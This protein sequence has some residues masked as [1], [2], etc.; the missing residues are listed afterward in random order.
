MI[1]DEEISRIKVSMARR[2]GVI[3][4]TGG[5]PFEVAVAQGQLNQYLDLC[6]DMGFLRIECG[7]GF[8]DIDLEPSAVV[9]MAHDRGLEVQF[10]LGEKHAGSFEANTVE[11]LIEQGKRWLDAGAVH[12]IVEGRE[13]AAEVGIFSTDG[14]L[15]TGFA[16]RFADAFGLETVIFEA[17]TKPSQ[18]ALLDHF[19][20]HVRLSNV[21]LEE[22]LR[23][24]IY[25]RGLH[26]DAFSN[27]RLRPHLSLAPAEPPGRPE[28]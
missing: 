16:E 7:E 13:N 27:P 9:E 28:L 8:T 12:L 11:A 23:V 24:E 15:H 20:P 21:R 14:N 3:P 25:R 4:T 2:H 10:E 26:S 1:A 17:P 6:A 18:F 5:G 22:L 19:G